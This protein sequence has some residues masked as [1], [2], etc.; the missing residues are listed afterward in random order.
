MV[1]IDSQEGKPSRCGAF[2]RRCW[3]P[4]DTAG[5]TASRHARARRW[6]LQAAPVVTPRRAAVTPTV[7]PRR[8]AVT[9]TV[10]P[11][12]PAPALCLISRAP[13]PVSRK[14][15]SRWAGCRVRRAGG[16]AGRWNMDGNGSREGTPSRFGAYVRRCFTVKQG[17]CGYPLVL[18]RIR[19]KLPEYAQCPGAR[20]LGT[21]GGMSHATQN[22]PQRTR[23]APALPR[24]EARARTCPE[25]ANAGPKCPTRPVTLTV[26]GGARD[27]A[28][29]AVRH[30]GGP[31]S[32]GR[33]VVNG[34]RSAALL[35]APGV[36]A[37]R[38]QGFT[39]S[40]LSRHGVTRTG[41]RRAASHLEQS[42]EVQP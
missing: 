41:D 37:A 35:R 40:G 2:M 23:R 33:A 5:R 7:T 42:G 12:Y 26:R 18:A 19:R 22:A 21:V 24:W 17:V 14:G 36:R 11:G 39:A 27:N 29:R 32:W 30:D 8:A 3:L 15:I 10:T 13:A 4:G 38:L 28:A 20:H 6:S 16:R 9:P 31:R 25:V 34:T 1:G